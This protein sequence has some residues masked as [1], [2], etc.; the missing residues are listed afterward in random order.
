MVPHD[1]MKSFLVRGSFDQF[2]FVVLE[3]DPCTQMKP[4]ERPTLFWH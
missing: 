2:I 3:I 4:S 1:V